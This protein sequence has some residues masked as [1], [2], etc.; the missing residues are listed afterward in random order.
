MKISD[1]ERITRKEVYGGFEFE[2]VYRK[3]RKP[4]S[5][6]YLQSLPPEKKK[7]LGAAPEIN[8]RSYIAEPGILCEQDVP[9]KLRDGV[10]IYADIFRPVGGTDVPAILSWSFFGKRPGE[11]MAD[12]QILGVPPQTVSTMAK[13]EG[14]DPAYW[15]RHG[16][17]I[18]NV[19]PRGVGRSEGDLK[20]HGEQSGLDG[21]DFIEW[22]AT[23]HWCN[24]KVGMSGNSGL[25]MAQWR[26]AATNP[27]HLACIAPWEATGD[28][29]REGLMDGGIPAVGFNDDMLNKLTGQG[30]L[31]DYVAMMQ[32][33]P[34]MN[35]YW[36]DKIPKYSAITVPAYVTPGWS[37]FH[38]QGSIEGFRKIKSAKKWLR[39]HREFE[40]PDYYTP[41]YLED[42]RAF[43][44]RY[45]KDIRN[46][47]ELTPRVRLEVMDAFDEDY[48]T[49]RPEKEFPLKRTEYKKLY[50]DGGNRSLSFEP[51][52]AE[53]SVSYD[54][55]AGVANFD[56]RF[57]EDTEITGFM[58]LHM[59]VEADGH[60]DMDLF[61]N[62]QKLDEEGN[63]LPTLVMDEPHPGA[64][65]KLRVSRRALDEKAS[66]HYM[67][68][69]AHTKDEKLAKGEI[70]PV[71]ME[72]WPTSKFWHKGQQ[73]RLQISG[74]YIREDGWFEILTWDTDNRGNH[75]IHTGGRYD[76][77]LQVPVIPPKYRA[78]NYARR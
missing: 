33:Y 4:V 49:D 25:A 72:I 45:L 12:Y 17:A 9:V 52:S 5:P 23:Q 53:A 36:E 30:W 14:P 35:A 26:I 46:G 7:G 68:V 28:Y 40:W 38:L 18:A 61:I 34:F 50:L 70:V 64:W 48:Q 39:V 77:F 22:I 74:R 37:H 1:A 20:F 29:Y 67:P 58:K 44:D 11:G 24:G 51:V 66:T 2:A 59:W 69:L 27:P 43:F 13:F 6:E 75:V 78:G 76:S 55:N 57:E 73:L 56:I 31:D 42:L 16:Y 62:V 8:Q 71:D 63:W 54:G 10:T 41:K 15:C 60:D 21:Y 65:G 19:D 3:A 47:W 32:R